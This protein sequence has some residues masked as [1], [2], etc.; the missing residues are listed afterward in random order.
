MPLQWLMFGNVRDLTL[1]NQPTWSTSRKTWRQNFMLWKECFCHRLAGNNT[2]LINKSS[3]CGIL[4]FSRFEGLWSLKA[5]FLDMS[6]S[7]VL[8][9]RW[10][11][12]VPSVLWHCWLGVR[13]SIRP[14]KVEWWDVGVVICLEQG[15]YCL[16][17]VQLMPLH[18]KTSS[19]LASFKSR[20]VLPFLYRL[21]QVSWKGGR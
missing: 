12:T 21:T 19:S 16:Y 4:S 3:F 15:A 9:R 5:V 14:V 11:E 10:R 17:V 2:K 20:L 7:V 8:F 13:K 1:L 18:S 6:F